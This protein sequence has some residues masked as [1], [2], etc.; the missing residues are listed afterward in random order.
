MTVQ[1]KKIQLARDAILDE[2]RRR[3]K[4]NADRDGVTAPS[5]ISRFHHPQTNYF[6]GKGEMDCPIC[7]TGKLHYDRSPHNGH[8]FGCCSGHVGEGCVWWRE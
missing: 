5:D 7:K 6:C 8:V 4:D 3:W 1:D 2:L